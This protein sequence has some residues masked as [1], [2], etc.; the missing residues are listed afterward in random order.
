MNRKVKV[1][2]TKA[3]IDC[4]RFFKNE[5]K[6]KLLE[7]LIVSLDLEQV[8]ISVLLETCLR[9]QMFRSLVHVCVSQQD[10]VTPI[11][12][13]CGLVALDNTIR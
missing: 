9:F 1:I 11:I 7:V 8:E 3:L 4:I 2:P 13:L 6:D 5:K 10:Y 12:K